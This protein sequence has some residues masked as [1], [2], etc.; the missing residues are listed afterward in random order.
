MAIGLRSLSMRLGPYGAATRFTN[1]INNNK[2]VL[3]LLDVKSTTGKRDTTESGYVQRIK[4]KE[5]M[6]NIY[7]PAVRNAR[8]DRNYFCSGVNLKSTTFNDPTTT[9]SNDKKQKGNEQLQIVFNVLSSTLPNLFVKPLDY[10]IFHTNLVVENN[11]RGTRTVG[12]YHF[13]KQV[14]L[15]RTVGHIK[16]G[17][18]KFDV[19]KMTMHPEDDT[20]KIR[21]S[22]RGISGLKIMLQFWKFKLWE[23]KKIREQEETW[24]DGF[25]TMYVGEDGLV[26]KHVID[27]VIPDQNRELD[28]ITKGTLIAPKLALFVGLTTSDLSQFMF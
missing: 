14:A 16:Y 8:V 13:V 21:W 3:H 5:C 2:P 7:L 6:P 23:F 12:L 4:R 9:N 17:Y 19:L 25:S 18:V 1:E 11:I 27:K 15:L 20:I 26:F 24:Y 10:S 28:T 22:V